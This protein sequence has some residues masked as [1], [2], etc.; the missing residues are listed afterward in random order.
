MVY[1][2]NSDTEEREKPAG[3]KLFRQKYLSYA[4]CVSGAVTDKGTRIDESVLGWQ[5]GSDFAG[6]AVP[7]QCFLALFT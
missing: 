1:E 3:E 5:L 7:Q 6:T 2:Y 4:H